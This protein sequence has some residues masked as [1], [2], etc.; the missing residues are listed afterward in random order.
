MPDMS[1]AQFWWNWWVSLA[2][3]IGTIG[4]VLVA[5]FSARPSAQTSSSSTRT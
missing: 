4:A 2:V 1:A 5:L 3:A